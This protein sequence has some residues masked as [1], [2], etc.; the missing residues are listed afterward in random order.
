M[1]QY[2]CKFLEL[3]VVQYDCKFL[4]LIVVQYE[5]KFLELE[6]ANTTVSSLVL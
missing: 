4:E 2:D 6:Y 1:V 5:C 3:V